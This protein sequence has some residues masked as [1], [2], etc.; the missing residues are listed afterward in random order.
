MLHMWLNGRI[1]EPKP[2]NLVDEEHILPILCEALTTST[3]DMQN[4][5]YTWIDFNQLLQFIFTFWSLY[6]FIY[7]ILHFYICLINFI[8]FWNIKY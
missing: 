4:L 1:N 8:H 2:N 6:I 7:F 5:P 3:A